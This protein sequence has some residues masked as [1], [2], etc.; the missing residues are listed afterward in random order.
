MGMIC[1]RLVAWEDRLQDLPQQAAESLWVDVDN[2]EAWVEGRRITLT[3]QRFRLLRYLY[4]RAN[5]LCRRVDIAKHVFDVDFSDLRP[6]E[7]ELIERD[8]INTNISRLRNDIEPN[9]SYPKYIV[10]VHG[11]GYKLILGGIPS[12]NET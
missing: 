12:P 7:I 9:P 4:D 11:A 5:Q 8:Q 2:Q 6:A 1:Q 10:T 3:P